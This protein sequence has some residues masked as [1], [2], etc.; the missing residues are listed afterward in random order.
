MNAPTDASTLA[1]EST[2]DDL[3]ER[4]QELDIEGRSEMTKDELAAAVADAENAQEGTV[5][6]SA[7]RP[8]VG[9][10]LSTGPVPSTAPQ[11][12]VNPERAPGQAPVA[13]RSS[14][15]IGERIKRQRKLSGRD[16]E[17]GAPQ[18]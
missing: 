13:T 5:A 8:E 17:T 2:R 7:L 18:G 10:P 3:Y 16:A 1:D 6:R 9:S 4:A 14:S 12:D 15:R 11:R